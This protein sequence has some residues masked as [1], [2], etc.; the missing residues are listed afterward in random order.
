VKKLTIAIIAACAAA[1]AG[2][3]G[4][5]SPVGLLDVQRLTAN[6]PV[7]TNAQNQLN[8]DRQ[9]IVSGKGSN[10]DKQRQAAA[11]QQRYAQLSDQLVSQVRAAATKI[12][13]QKQLKL[14]VTR[15]FVGYGG[16][17]ITADVE[18]QLGITEK[19]SPTP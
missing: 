16:T 13:Q 1:L 11:L 9:A 2:C 6:W 8:A 4:P 7:F 12:A 15:E 10:A 19:P 14:V 3:G 17:D 5:S 18:K